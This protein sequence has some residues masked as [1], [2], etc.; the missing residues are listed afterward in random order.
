MGPPSGLPETVHSTQAANGY[1]RSGANGGGVLI[2]RA[3]KASDTATLTANGFNAYNTGREG[4]GGGGAGGSVLLTTQQGTLSGL[5]V[6][7]KGG[8]GGS[9][10]ILQAPAGDP[11]ERHGPGGGGGGGCH[12]LSTAAASTKGPG[13]Q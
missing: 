5:T 8:N 6:Q 10:W 9:A 2:T 11:G 3:V 4:S 1:D 7:T 12:L 13:G